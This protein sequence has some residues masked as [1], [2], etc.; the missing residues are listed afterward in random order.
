MISEELR[1]YIDEMI[2][3]EG[4]YIDALKS[5]TLIDVG[6]KYL[7]FKRIQ[8]ADS[9]LYYRYLDMLFETTIES[10]ELA[11]ELILILK[12]LHQFYWDSEL[13]FD[14][15]GIRTTYNHFFSRFAKEEDYPEIKQYI[16]SIIHD[17][18]LNYE[19]FFT[20]IRQQEECRIERES[21]IIPDIS[22]RNRDDLP[23]A[24][25]KLS[26][27]DLGFHFGL[28]PAQLLRINSHQQ[29]II[30]DSLNGLLKAFR[31]HYLN[32]EDLRTIQRKSAIR[33]QRFFDE[34]IA[35]HLNFNIPLSV[36]MGME[37]YK[38]IDMINNTD[39]LIELNQAIGISIEQYLGLNQRNRH[40][41]KLNMEMITSILQYPEWTLKNILDLDLEEQDEFLTHIKKI[42]ALIQNTN[43]SC[44]QLFMVFPKF[45]NLIYRRA[46][47]LNILFTR[48]SFQ[49]ADLIRI[50]DSKH[51][52][53][54]I[55]KSYPLAIVSLR[56]KIGIQELVAHCFSTNNLLLVDETWPNLCLFLE[57]TDINLASIKYLHPDDFKMIIKF[58]EDIAD[59]I[60]RNDLDSNFFKGVNF[61]LIKLLSRIH[62]ESPERFMSKGDDLDPLL[63][64]IQDAKIKHDII[65]AGPPHLLM[66]RS[67]AD[68]VKGP[69]KKQASLDK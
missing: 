18:I 28:N 1:N 43:I 38:F 29:N 40:R 61:E 66:S 33:Y 46:D 56:T 25:T 2:G 3:P 30:S 4:F 44:K 5:S 9:A 41:F 16:S 51:F 45:R 48:T 8:M 53:F 42:S 23:F 50:H 26:I 7:Y 69:T 14:V 58:A 6:T 32:F 54:I 63:K 65:Q 36:M 62:F 37:H 57:Y 24:F 55:N 17:H 21:R 34:I 20:N 11:D 47:D 39:S 35:L 13:K 19:S 27:E 68:A 22:W 52:S 31:G 15:F 49:F 10:K 59:I 67:Y 64:R 12:L 60:Q